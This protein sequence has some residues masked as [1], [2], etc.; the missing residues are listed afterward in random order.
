VE[1][2]RPGVTTTEARAVAADAVRAIGLD[3]NTR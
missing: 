1:V 3:R 2:S